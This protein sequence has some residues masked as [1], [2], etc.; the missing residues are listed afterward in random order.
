M[1]IAA[2]GDGCVSIPGFRECREICGSAITAEPSIRESR[3]DA[4][5]ASGKG[6]HLAAES[7]FQKI[8]PGARVTCPGAFV[9][10][11]F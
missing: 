8:S 4:I 10:A 3:I 6:S 2:S 9:L 1:P 7:E 5:T 11:C